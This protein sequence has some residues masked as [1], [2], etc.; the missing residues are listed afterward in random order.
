MA[1]IA[2]ALLSD[3]LDMLGLQV[4][5]DDLVFQGESLGLVLACCADQDITCVIVHR[6]RWLA[7]LSAHSS[8]WSMATVEREVWEVPGVLLPLAWKQDGPREIVVIR[9]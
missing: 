4:S 3:S 9:M 7:N 5:V 2:G 6:L 8:R 1:G